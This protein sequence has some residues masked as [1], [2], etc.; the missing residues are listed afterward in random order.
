MLMP[1]AVIFIG[2]SSHHATNAPS[3]CT[4]MLAR[5]ATLSPS[6]AVVVSHAQE[7]ADPI[8]LADVA[9]RQGEPGTRDIT[10]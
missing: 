6:V 10:R 7:A 8:L 3:S 1:L 5:S 9:M 2:S 4:E